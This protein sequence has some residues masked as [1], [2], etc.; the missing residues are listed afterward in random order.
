MKLRDTTTQSA[1]ALSKTIFSS[2]STRQQ[3]DFV[4]RF[5]AQVL[6]M[7]Y[8][9]NVGPEWDS[10]R[11]LESDYL[12]HIEICLSGRRQVVFDNEV[13]DL[14][15]GQAYWFPGNTPLERRW[16]EQFK[17][18]Y[19]KLQCEW[20]PGLDPFLDWP[21]RRPKLIGSCDLDSWRA[22]LKPD[23][24]PSTNQL[25]H[26][27]AWVLE[28]IAKVI[29]DLNG[30]LV[31]HLKTHA[32]FNSVF[33]LIEEKLGGDLRIEEL[34]R[35]YGTSLHAFSMSFARNTG[36]AP[37]AYLKRRLNK[38]AILLVLNTN[39]KIKEIAEQLKFC[40]E[41]HFIRFF[42]QMNGQPPGQY[43]MSL[44][45]PVPARPKHGS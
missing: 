18:I 13:L 17:V 4:S 14:L 24:E 34:A 20:L 6:G 27:H 21:G 23:F 9:G 22:W 12:H 7:Y 26:L 29:P 44:H 2:A 5:R 41:Y 1:H 16:K 30:L 25:L 37:K 3:M 39:L 43:R 31:A 33:T 38:E 32:K 10:G 35:A 45:H 8:N 36:L 15:P 42:N 19:F 40:D 11:K 28:S